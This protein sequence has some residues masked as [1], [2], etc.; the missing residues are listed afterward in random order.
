MSSHNRNPTGN[1]QYGKKPGVDDKALVAALTE[2][3]RQGITNN[4]LISQLLRADHK[5]D[6]SDTTVK[7]RRAKLK[8]HASKVQEKLL[9]KSDVEQLVLD[10]IAKD[11]GLRLGVNTIF[12]RVPYWTGKHITRKTVSRVMH[13]HYPEGFALR[14]PTAKKIF[15]MPIEPK[16]IHY[17][18]S[19]DGHDK[20][21]KIGFAVYAVVD[22][23]SSKIL[24]GWVMPSN[25]MGDAVAACILQLFIKYE[26]MP[27][28]LNMDCGSE[29]TRVFGLT[30]A[31][32][33][34][35]HPEVDMEENP[36]VVY[37]KS[38]HNVPIERTWV[39]LR[40]DFGDNAIIFFNR[41]VK[42]GIYNAH[43]PNQFELCQW[44]WAKALRFEMDAW[45]DSRNA[46]PKRKDDNKLG[47]SGMSRNVAFS[48]PHK[49]G[50]TNKLLPV[51]P[52]YV[53]GLL[54]MIGGEEL[55][56]FHSPEYNARAQAVYDGLRV[57]ELSS[58][59]AW[60]VFS[61]MYPLMYDA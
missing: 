60:S 17:R 24:G 25:R 54:D 39:R 11:P 28:V 57:R 32:R 44:V 46:A 56:E 38:V 37:L 15:R 40:F 49:W 55:L 14:D 23:D 18:W 12:K 5:I 31:L 20:L 26:G 50:G 30:H 36:P 21:L 34:H 41:G 10:Q 1:N 42:A 61:A 9:S 35:F 52:N 33:E 47:P 7:R 45:I 48:L 51:D 29:T 8:K 6:I 59:N 43:N 3:H 53:R 27:L 4:L 22:R 13:E 16:G 58:Q 2:Y 19:A